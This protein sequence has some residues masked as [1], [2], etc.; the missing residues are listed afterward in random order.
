MSKELHGVYL[1][2]T[3]RFI[4]LNSWRIEGDF[5]DCLQEAQLK[6][7]HCQNKYGEVDPPHLMSLFQRSIIRHFHTL[8][9]KRSKYIDIQK[10]SAQ[11]NSSYLKEFCINGDK[12]PV[13]ILDMQRGLWTFL[14]KVEFLVMGIK[15]ELCDATGYQGDDTS[16]LLD[17]A[18]KMSDEVFIKLS[19]QAQDWLDKAVV[20]SNNRKPLPPLEVEP[21]APKPATSR[22]AAAPSAN[23]T[24]KVGRQSIYPDTATIELLIRGNPKRRNSKAHKTFELYKDGMTI[25]ELLA[26]GGTRRGLNWDM[27]RNF[28]R[29]E[30]AK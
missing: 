10:A 7:I 3:K 16:S 5:D 22:A 19:S 25:G 9:N 29:V 17:A 21:K 24:R 26:A 30:L 18:D 23:G 11:Q 28:I 14:T 1:A 6:F 13:E 15:Q 12:V 27:E 20:A 2:W 8:S 4:S